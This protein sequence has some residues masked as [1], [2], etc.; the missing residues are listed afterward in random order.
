VCY[1]KLME[2]IK[3]LELICALGAV[4]SI[5]VY[6]N[7]AWYAPLIGLFCQIFWVSWS[8]LGGFHSMFILSGAMILTHIRNL[9]TMGTIQKLKQKLLK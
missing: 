2:L 3:I 5:Y 6:G 4:A 9:R 8:I 1:N 7:K